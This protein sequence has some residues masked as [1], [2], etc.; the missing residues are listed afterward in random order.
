MIE[1]DRT[2]IRRA[3]YS[4]PVRSAIDD[5]IIEPNNEVFD[6]GCGHGDDL[7]HLGENGITAFG[8]D[9]VHRPHE[10]P[11]SADVVNLGYV[12]NVVENPTERLDVL[13]SAWQLARDVLVVSARLKTESD[14]EGF[15]EFEDGWVTRLNT[16]QKFYEQ[17]ELR[18]WIAD[19][20]GES[21]VAAC[22][23]V[24]YVFRDSERRERFL[25]SRYRR[26][27]AVPRIRLSNRLFEEHSELL[28][29]LISFFADR[30]RL[31]ERDELS[32]GT[33][34]CAVFGSLRK[35]FQIVRRA[36]GAIH[37]AALEAERK[38]DLLVYLALGR[39]P[40][41]P[42]FSVLPV[43]LQR[44]IRAHFGTY[45]RG[46]DAADELLFQSGRPDL[47][48]K[49][50]AAAEIGKLMPTALYVHV[51]GLA[52]LPPLLRVYEG[53]ARVL[54]G[55]F[56]G[57]TIV[58]LRRD[59]P[60]VSYLCYPDFDADPH[61]A[62]QNSLRVDLRTFHLKVRD[63]HNA[64][65]PPILHRKELFVDADYPQRD[66]FASLTRTEEAAGLF[67][68]PARIGTRQTW[69]ELLRTFAVALDGHT[70]ISVRRDTAIDS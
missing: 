27:L 46:C 23:G 53:C 6:Y 40:R 34:L 28:Q 15:R 24:F 48:D 35:A 69:E 60:K 16:F 52:L 55:S 64:E 4:L 17:Q 39:F 21:P 51:S 45:K 8:W 38:T 44:D 30:G 18:D 20:L 1:R 10:T 25:A 7:R 41:R 42:K 31:P 56:D 67:S 13:R 57:T 61:P 49:A 26:R 32:T 3:G 62:L 47:I 66:T 5:G 2:A 54:S 11:R 12:V 59:E 33:S 9:P 58:K 65:N 50:C 36:S 22:P 68:D 43:V 37:W 70:L 14:T 19:G 63:F 29:P